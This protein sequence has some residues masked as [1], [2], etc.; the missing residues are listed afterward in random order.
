MRAAVIDVMDMPSLRALLMWSA[1]R[2]VRKLIHHRPVTAPASLE[3]QPQPRKQWMPFTARLVLSAPPQDFIANLIV[4]AQGLN[5]KT[6]IIGL[7]IIRICDE[8]SN[9]AA[10][11]EVCRIRFR[12]KHSLSITRVLGMTRA[13]NALTHD[14]LRA[15]RLKNLLK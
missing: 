1:L 5:F 13:C 14:M 15:L 4:V 6:D 10:L 7:Y 11:F 8:N 12:R 9:C 2:W 3:G